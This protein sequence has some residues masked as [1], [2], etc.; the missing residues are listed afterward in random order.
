[1]SETSMESQKTQFDTLNKAL[2]DLTLRFNTLT[3]AGKKLQK[4]FE[5]AAKSFLSAPYIVPVLVPGPAAHPEAARPDTAQPGAEQKAGGI[6]GAAL[7]IGKKALGK[8]FDMLTDGL[9]EKGEEK[10]FGKKSGEKRP[11][12]FARDEDAGGQAGASL[13]GK[14]AGMVK[15]GGTALAKPVSGKNAVP[16]AILGTA[17]GITAYTITSH[18]V[19]GTDGPEKKVQDANTVIPHQQTAGLLLKAAHN[20]NTIGSPRQAAGVPS[21]TAQNPVVLRQQTASVLAAIPVFVMNWPASSGKQAGGEEPKGFIDTVGNKLNDAAAKAAVKVIISFLAEARTILF[22]SMGSL[23]AATATGIATLPLT[24]TAAAYGLSRHQQ[25]DSAAL[26]KWRT[27]HPLDYA[28]EKEV[29][30][31]KPAIHKQLSP[32]VPEYAVNWSTVKYGGGDRVGNIARDLLHSSGSP[33]QNQNIINI[34]LKVDKDNRLYA[35]T[36]DM[37]TRVNLNR[38]ELLN[39]GDR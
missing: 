32:A 37:N 27:D 1:M 33:V 21:G 24:L 5:T 28:R 22:G 16:A 35:G 12:G 31:I 17:T 11:I 20:S 38:G 14:L 39:A 29:I 8:F 4:S 25:K 6:G 19:K 7:E 15:A 10:I 18:L 36:K 9:I 26:V 2:D 23:A 13:R 34:A 3:E 30:G